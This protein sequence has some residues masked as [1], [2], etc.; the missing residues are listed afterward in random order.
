MAASAS[1]RVTR[2]FEADGVDGSRL[3][4]VGVFVT[5]EFPVRVALDPRGVVG[6]PLCR[7]RE[8]LREETDLLLLLEEGPMELDLR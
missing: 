3:F 4:L 6:S 2:A 5:L 8:G 7:S 1:P